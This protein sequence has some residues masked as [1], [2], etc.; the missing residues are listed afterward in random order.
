VK[1]GPAPLTHEEHLLLNEMI[2][3]LFG[4][5][6]PE[7]KRAVLESRLRPRLLALHL[8]R[9]IDYYLH[10]QCD[11]DGE[12]DLLAELVTNNETFFFR[13]T[14]QFDGLFEEALE[15]LKKNPAVPGTLRMLCAGCSS[16]EEP[17]TLGLWAR[18]HF[19][20][21]AGTEL[22]IDAFDIDSARLE[23]ARRAEYGR[24]SLRSTTSEQVER[25]FTPVEGAD[26]RIERWALKPAFRSGVRFSRGNILDLPTWR[27]PL[28]Y[29]VVFCRNVLIYFSE[30]ALHTAVRHFAQVLRPGGLLFLGSSESI[31]GMSDR[32]ET[33]RLAR[34]IVYRRVAAGAAAGM[35]SRV[36]R[37][38]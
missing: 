5:T 32:F 18:Q 16:G 37:G 30:P 23:M 12:R 7:H 19:V 33:V 4:I 21:W 8:P 25:L 15:G 38:G 17:Y 29:D 10:L 3:S 35:I 31:I 2:S 24:S 9:Y 14:H 20:R 1:T 6:F 11:T 36:G 13:E 34:S 22:A 26:P 27:S 28:L